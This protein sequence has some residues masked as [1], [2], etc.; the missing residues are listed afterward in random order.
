MCFFT[1]DHE[2]ALMVASP[3]HYIAKK[4]LTKETWTVGCEFD[5]QNNHCIVHVGEPM[6]T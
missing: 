4:M 5:H 1:G 3:V 2:I 6:T